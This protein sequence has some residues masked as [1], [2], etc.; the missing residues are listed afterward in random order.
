[1]LVISEWVPDDSLNGLR[2][3]DIAFLY[4][5]DLYRNPVA[6][7]EAL[8]LAQGLV[9]RNR[10]HVTETLLHRA[11][12]LRAVGRLGVGLDNIDVPACR[13]QGIA[14]VVP[15]GANAPSVVEYVV[16]ALLSHYRPWTPLCSD[17]Q[18][19]LWNRQPDGEEICG[20]VVGIVGYGDIGHRVGEALSALG[21]TIWAYDPHLGAF[22][23]AVMHHHV[24]RANTLFE[25]LRESD[26]VTLHAPLNASTF[27]MLNQETLAHCRQNA[28]LINTA[29]GDLIDEIALVDH[30]DRNRFDRVILDV[31]A[32]E[33]PAVP[34]ALTQ[35]HDRV[36]LTPHI[37]GV[38]EPAQRRITEWV[39]QEIAQYLG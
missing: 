17:M 31:R 22:D 3:K 39:F 5:P 13:E 11:P 12:Q 2:T 30:L 6:L 34:D 1:M 24:H 4:D 16:R 10:T 27:H 18:K 19:G 8:H 35:Y 20:K 14:L 9:V 15:R 7:G 28:V 37:A 29:R 23:R 25:L 38:T 26:I 32:K 21:T 33:P 36:W